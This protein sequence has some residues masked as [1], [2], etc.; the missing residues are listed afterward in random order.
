MTATTVSSPPRGVARRG[1]AERDRDRVATRVRC[2]S[3]SYGLSLR[4]GK[5]HTP[6]YW[7]SVSK[8]SRR[9][10]SELVHVRL[11]AD[12]PHDLVR[13]GSRAR[14]AGRG[15]LDHAEVRR[16]VAAGLRDR[17]DERLAD[18]GGELRR[19]AGRSSAF[20]SA[21]SLMES[22]MRSASQSARSHLRATGVR[23]G[24]APTRD[25]SISPA[26]RARQP[27]P[28]R[29]VATAVAASSASGSGVLVA[30][31]RSRRPRRAASSSA[32]A[33]S[34]SASSR[35]DP[36]RR[37]TSRPRPPRCRAPRPRRHASSSASACNAASAGFGAPARPLRSGRSSSVH[38]FAS[39]TPSSSRS[40]LFS[41]D[42]SLLAD[43]R[44]DLL[45]PDARLLERVASRQPSL[46]SPRRRLGRVLAPRAGRGCRSRTCDESSPP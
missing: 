23:T 24:A 37:P 44:R 32:T 17:V 7:R 16:E 25:R 26:R 18:L 4:F 34:P 35:A 39:R 20:R 38:M 43:L 46:A 8:R 2:R 40:R 1:D 21:A 45:E 6:P 14:G 29:P 41:S 28:R 31:R 42:V 15:E 3:T 10:V 33:A 5:P 27:Q 22:R 12:V 19:A 36:P 9:P 13:R 30:A 11:V